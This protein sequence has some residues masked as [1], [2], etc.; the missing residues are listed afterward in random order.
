MALGCQPTYAP[1]VR[2]PS[3]GAPQ[4]LDRGEKSVA[5]G[6]NYVLSGGSQLAVGV[7][8]RLAVEAGTDHYD[9]WH[10]G[11]LGVRY[12][13]VD[14]RRRGRL[15]RGAFDVEAGGG[16]GIGGTLCGGDA[17]EELDPADE[18]WRHADGKEWFERAAG[19]GYLGYGVGLHIAWFAIYGR[20][21]GQLTGA[22]NVPATLWGTAALGV[23]ATI[24]RFG[25]I[26][27]A[28]ES[29]AYRNL[30]DSERG[31]VVLDGGIGVRFGAG[32]GKKA[33]A[34]WRSRP[35]KKRK[36][37][38]KPRASLDAQPRPGQ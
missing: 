30:L 6:V 16:A 20:V 22:T 7:T 15:V 12:S 10:M 33:L 5:A 19:G 29:F 26:Y 28:T 37:S 24:L 18:C 21:R 13:A 4:A 32:N 3:Y 23:Q 17:R 25:Y 27:L 2:T 35:E 38:R 36:K 31:W 9:N 1:P 34:D 8:D 14:G 11:S